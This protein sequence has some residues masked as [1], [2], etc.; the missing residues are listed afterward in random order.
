MARPKWRVPDVRLAMVGAVFIVAWVG[1]GFRLVDVQGFHSEDY[2]ARGFDQRVK[3]EELP[4]ARGTIFDRD[5][6]ELAVT[7]DAVT[8]TA[9]PSLIAEPAVAARLLAPKVG[10]DEALLEERLSRDS[11][12][13]YVVRRLD[14]ATADEVEQ[15]LTDLDLDGFY[16]ETEPHRVYPAGPLAAQV[17]GFVR[18]DDGVGL[19]GI[20]YQYNDILLG[21]AGSQIVER[22]PGGRPIPQGQYLVQP[23]EH[24]VSL[25]TTLD[26][27]IQYAAEHALLA[28]IEGT[29]AV[30]ATAIV[31][32]V[33]TGEILA[34]ATVPT[35]DLN[36]RTGIDSAL[37]R[38]R[39][40]SDMYEPGS[41][42][43]VVTIAAALE[44]GVVETSTML[45]VPAE[46]EIALETEPKIYT[47]VGRKYEEEMSVAEIVSRSSNIGTILIQ[48]MIGNDIHHR[49]LAAFGLG[50]L[51]SGSFPGEATG[52]LRPAA[53]WCETTCGPNTAIG[54][55]VD[56]TPLQMAS[57]FATIANNGV[58]V[59]PHIVQ[60]VINPDLT[61]E[62]YE[63]V[64]RPVLSE[65]T[66]R[67][68][69][70]L[71]Q[72]V[73]ESSRGTGRRA[74]VEG[75]TVGG[76]T[77]TTEK[78]LQELQG[79]SEDDRIAS[80]IGLAPVTDP[81]IVVAVVLDSPHGLNEDGDELY[82]GG[83]S[84]A[85]VFAEIAEA[86]LHQLGVAPDAR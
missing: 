32:E 17:L 13:A 44:E 1:V 39:A 61:R 54:Y 41:T 7:V 27:E 16:F 66:A 74:A 67:I 52:T 21:T 4:A 11:R 6:A 29:E 82:F 36:D 53:D 77:G 80:F 70:R 33:K 73:V 72:G 20:E 76:K 58:W 57:V 71:L 75:Y 35:Y 78:Y 79:Y 64:K 65:H 62:P 10:T 38:N 48:D 14:R 23:P 56:V 50:Q 49:Y 31:L 81:Q 68:M 2:A 42:A 51:S 9:D 45:T 18:D 69:Q 55:R 5:G 47:D 22:D 24:G 40:V 34:M 59:E 25:V 26:R 12:F 37:F 85:P 46:Y 84:A 86:A 60:E 28:A 3:H 19:E 15:L 83:V 30:G 8:I 43:K 63:P